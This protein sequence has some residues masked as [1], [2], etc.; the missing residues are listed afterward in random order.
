MA[1]WHGRPYE[2]Q[3]PSHPSP[4]YGTHPALWD[5]APNKAVYYDEAGKKVIIHSSK[6]PKR[7]S[8]SQLTVFS[9]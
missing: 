3:C 1:A 8:P 6:L 9:T 2:P 5:P 7:T 4:A